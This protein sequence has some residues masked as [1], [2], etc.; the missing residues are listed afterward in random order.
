MRIGYIC[1]DLARDMVI[2]S[3]AQVFATA[4]AMAREGHDVCLISEDLSHVRRRSLT[5]QGRLIWYPVKPERQRHWYFTDRHAYADRVYDTLRELHNDKPFDVFEFID[6]GGEAL[7]ALRA[8]RL[9]GQFP[10]TCF[11]VSLHP[12]SST[13]HGPQAYQPIAFETAVTAYAEHYSRTHADLLVA[14]TATVARAFCSLADRVRVCPPCLPD[15]KFTKGIKLDAARTMVWLGPIHP[16]AGLETFLQ[17]ARLAFEK[18]PDL[19]VMVLG[20]D[21]PTDPVGQSYVRYLH[22]RLPNLLRDIIEFVEPVTVD[23]FNRLPA[24]TQCFLS[25]GFTSSPFV[26]LLAMSAGHIVTAS[27][28]SI[29]ADVVRDGECGRVLPANDPRVL[30]EAMLITVSDPYTAERIAHAAVRAFKKKRCAASCLTAAYQ[31]VRCD[32]RIPRPKVQRPNLSVIIPVY[33]QGHFL[34]DALNSVRSSGYRDIELVVVDDGSTDAATVALIN[35]LTDVTKVRQKNCGLSAARNVGISASSGQFILTLDAD[36]KVHPEFI[37]AAVAALLRCCDIGFIA[38]YTRY[39]GLLDLVYVPVGPVPDINLVL[40]THHKSM[41]FYRREALEHVGG[42]DERMP[43]FEDW[44]IQLRLASAGYDSDILP[45][46]G[47]LYRR[48]ANSMSFKES[49]AMRSELVQYIVRTQ[50]NTLTCASL[51]SLL[52]TVIDLWKTGYEPSTSVQL[53]YGLNEQ[54]RRP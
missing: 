10:A 25:T 48:H 26:A 51:T 1:Q 3:G 42:Y 40:Q 52:L 17:A 34:P 54:R 38:G 29:G 5:K 8:K 16:N 7:T 39:F 9:L 14:G 50:V 33:N 47:Q 28:G 2:G 46:E 35:S 22:R 27:T 43:A 12:W 44:E 11:S 18:R 24:G 20:E 41:G 23:I 15:V 31:S 19:H 53:Q 4:D 36:D 49:N 6:A 37:P 13:N 45:I 21:T 30:A 32:V